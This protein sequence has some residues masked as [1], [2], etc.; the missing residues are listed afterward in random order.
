MDDDLASF[1]PQSFGKGK[2]SKPTKKT[3]AADNDEWDALREFLPMSFGK[4]E[5]KKDTTSFFDK[6]KREDTTEL[7]RQRVEASSEISSEPAKSTTKTKK[8]DDDGDDDDDNNDNANEDDAVADSNILPITHEVKLKDHTRTVSALTLDPAGARLVTGGYDYDVKF[9]DFAG[10]DRSF[11]PFR[12]IEPCGGHQIHELQYS[13]TGDRVLIISGS[14]RAKLYSRDGNEVCE[15]VKGDPYI[16][17][18]RHTDGHIAALT[19]GCW[20]PTDQQTFATSSQDGSLRLWDVE[21]KRKQK[22]VIVYKSRERGGRSPAT[23]ITYSPDAKLIAGAFQ[24]GSINL[25]GANGPFLRPSHAITDAHQKYTETSCLLFSKDNHTMVSRGGDDSVKV[26]D[27]RNLKN[28]VRTAYNLDTVNPEANVIFSPDERLILT[29]TSVPKGKGYGKLVMLDRETLE[30]QRTMSITQSSVV[31]V[32]WHP[33]INQIITGSA[34]GSVGVFYSPTH[35]TRGAKLCVVRE[36]KRRAVDDYEIDR[37]IITPHALPMFKDDQPRSS[38]RKREKLRKD[39]VVSH[40]PDMPVKGPGKGGRVGTN[41]QQSVI[42]GFGKDTTRD[43]D[44]R[45]AL[46]KY[47]KQA[48]EEPMWIS[49]MYKK[50]Q[51]K[52]IFKEDQEEDEGEG[53]NK[54]DK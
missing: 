20:H 21:Q 47:A 11:R 8:V 19:N 36:E 42:A 27:I 23:A 54:K 40:R 7:K 48:E 51:P 5:K 53:S 26:W 41:E 35:S 33:R 44:P 37:P 29:G 43:E 46:L 25:W 13:L 22:S 6:T 32:L 18:M 50:T 31:R 4:K 9:W 14:A 10:M 39:P 15:Y 12:S 49:N 28:P 3:A 34:D 45:E 1:L 30:V 2:S 52:P 24:D 17:D 16:R 38:K